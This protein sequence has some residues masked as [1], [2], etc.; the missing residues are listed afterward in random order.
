MAVDV[1]KEINILDPDGVF[2]GG[3]LSQMNGFPKEALTRAI[4]EN[5]RKPYPTVN[6]Q[7][8]FSAPSPENGIIGAAIEDFRQLDEYSHSLV[9]YTSIRHMGGAFLQR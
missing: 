3:W 6:L 7:M 1:A 8:Y 4:L 5:T 2:L 9:V